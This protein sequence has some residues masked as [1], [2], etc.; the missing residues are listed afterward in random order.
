VR[1]GQWS[2]HAA[3]DSTYLF[4]NKPQRQT[5][6]ISLIVFGQ[7]GGIF[8]RFFLGS[9]PDSTFRH[10]LNE[11]TLY[12]LYLGIGQ[13]IAVYAA[14]V[15]FMYTGEHIT[16]KLR[17]EYLEAVLRQNIAVFDNL[18]AGEITTAITA[19]MDLVLVGISE[20]VALTIIAFTTLF[21]ALVVGFVKSWRLSFVLLSVAFAV[22]FVMGGFSAFI[23]RY[24]KRS[25][26]AYAPGTA[27][28]EEVLT[29]MRTVTAFNGQTKLA[30]RFEDCL[31]ST[32]RWG[33]RVKIS[34]GC[35]IA[36]MMFVTYLEY[37]LGFWEGSRLLVAGHGALADTLTVLLAML[38]GAV[39]IAHAAPHIQA[40]AGGV[41]A[42]ANIFKII[43]RPLPENEDNDS[44]SKVPHSIQGTLE[45]RAL[46]HVY[47]S[48]PEVTVLEDFN[49][50][51]PAGKVTALVGASGSGKS[52]IVGLIERF[53]TPIGGQILLDN[54]D[55]QKLD[56]KW[57]RRQISI[58]SQE[59]V[60][61][62]GSIRSNIEYGL[63]GTNLD[64][65]GLEKRGE[66][67]IQA[68][69][70]AN[71]HDFISQLPNRYETTA[72]PGGV[73]L[74]GG[75]KQRIAIARA[76]ISNPKILLL[77]EA[78]SALD[79]QSEGVVQAALD[80]AAQ[81]RTTIVI[82]HRLSTINKA[83]NIVVLSNSRIVEQGTHDHLLSQN[84][85]YLKL[86]QAQQ[87]TTEKDTSESNM[88]KD[89]DILLSSTQRA[90]MMSRDAPKDDPNLQFS[91]S[92][93]DIELQ[94]ASYGPRDSLWIIIKVIAAFNK[95]ETGVMIFGLFCS[96]LAGG[97]MPVQGIIFAKS[98]I[99][100]SL[101]P[102]HYS[103]FA[104]ISTSGA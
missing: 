88:T 104:L 73:L 14:V 9:I 17:E 51:V 35:M 65:A 53:Y 91:S 23:V 37:G 94:N 90:D 4:W 31:L 1:D 2:G 46:K 74:S 99:A 18:G 10:R 78:T 45:F 6:Y 62:D 100:L 22:M 50:V 43:D 75:Q 32:M 76:I 40:F 84:G 48:R 11:L 13:F 47:P 77:D 21:T 41:A 59:P 30:K 5:A 56:L 12:F 39:S 54:H 20:K 87:L 98:I 79:S 27:L 7:L 24:N 95:P 33:F 96:I 26:E 19:N 83:D 71:A 89:S 34:V 60:L 85:V 103:H 44:S 49:L 38:M 70:I 57:L 86:I 52:T 42:A 92:A 64:S 66:L 68:A 3:D 102:T 25:L 61:F 63:T 69:K 8:Q 93:Q 55:I 72:G 15:G 16:Q 97:G 28:A 81:G 58:V 101:P 36:S 67:V 80:V 29:S 82:A